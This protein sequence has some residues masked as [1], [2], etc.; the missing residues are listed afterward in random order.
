MTPATTTTTTTTTLLW[1]VPTRAEARFLLPLLRDN[2]D[3]DGGG[4]DLPD[5]LRAHVWITRENDDRDDAWND[6]GRDGG[7]GC[8]YAS[9]SDSGAEEEEEAGAG[10]GADR[11]ATTMTTT[12]IA[13]TIA[14]SALAMVAS[15]WVC[16]LQPPPPQAEDDENEGDLPYRVRECTLLGR[17]SICRSCEIEDVIEERMDRTETQQSPLPP[18]PPCCTTPVC[19][20]CFRGVPMVLL[21]LVAPLLAVPLARFL[22][23]A[24]LRTF[25]AGGGGG[26]TMYDAIDYDDRDDDDDDNDRDEIEIRGGRC[27]DGDVEDRTS[28]SSRAGSEGSRRRRPTFHHGKRPATTAELMS[29]P[30]LP[31]AVFDDDDE[32]VVVV[33]GPPG[34]AETAR[35]DL[36]IDPL[37]KRW[38]VIEA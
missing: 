30:H 24:W 36:S 11:T 27:R 5:G 17:S 12:T 31:P 28:S 34:L 14:A 20:V 21:L 16:A 33:C 23:A 22:R 6:E 7:C 29:V 38:R 4:G 32:V 2:D 26:A 18:P 10:A 35:R 19:Q 15:R 1:M 37:R 8:G 9:L 25:G 13:A 3:V